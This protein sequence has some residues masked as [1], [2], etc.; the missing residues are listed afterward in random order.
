MA[1]GEMKNG[2]EL[3]NPRMLRSY[4]TSVTFL[5]IRGLIMILRTNSLFFRWVMR[6]VAADE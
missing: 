6:S 1:A 4:L 2:A 5:N 3:L